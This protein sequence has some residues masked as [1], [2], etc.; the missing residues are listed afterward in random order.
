MN[1]Y[2]KLRNKSLQFWDITTQIGNTV[3]EKQ[4]QDG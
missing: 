3:P 4:C 1:I 2:L